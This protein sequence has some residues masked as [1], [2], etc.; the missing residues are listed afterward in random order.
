MALSILE[1]IYRGHPKTTD[2]WLSF[3]KFA[4]SS[5][6]LPRREWRGGGTARAW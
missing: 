2:V 4:D 6:N 1:E 3:D 5:L